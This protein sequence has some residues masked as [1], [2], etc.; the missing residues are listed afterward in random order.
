MLAD[1]KLLSEGRSIQRRRT[2]EQWLG[3]FKKAVL[4]LTVPAVVA[5]A[6]VF[7][8][9]QSASPDYSGDGPPS[10]NKE[11][12]I[13]CEKG[14]LIVRGDNYRQ[15]ADAYTNFH[16]AI[17][18]DPIYAQPYIGLLELRLREYIPG[19][20]GASQEEMR[21]LASQ[22]RKLAPHSAA[23]YC[24]ESIVNW[25]DWNYPQAEKRVLQAIKSN[26]RY[27][28]AHTWY[29]FVL[30][31]WGRP[32]ESRAQLEIASSIA[33]AKITSYLVVGQ[34][35]YVQRDYTNAIAWEK[36]A[37]ELEPHH[38]VAF[39]MIATACQA[40]GDYTNALDNFEAENRYGGGENSQ[41][42]REFRLLRE[43]VTARGARGFWEERWNQ[44]EQASSWGAWGY[45]SYYWKAVIQIHLGNTDA[46][47][48]WLAKSYEHREC[49]TGSFEP[50]LSFV[51]LDESWDGVHVDPRFKAILEKIGFTRVM[52]PKS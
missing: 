33:P 29:G 9:R 6:F 30:C 49:R 32:I 10:T 20:P 17:D 8:T 22:L 31:M 39:Y 42:K 36:K 44:V 43:A 51:L 19:L 24:A 28:P 46:A 25:F 16:K 21:L 11:A 3:A 52:R 41:S 18:L 40:M 15:L 13:L 37:L 38:A 47:L 26:P 45:R 2:R 34:T 27:E 4:A 50:P 23:R 7:G 5:I 35:Y 48:D 1:L 12:T 14:L